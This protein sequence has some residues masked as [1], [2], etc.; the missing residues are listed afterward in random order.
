MQKEMKRVVTNLLTVKSIVTLMLT[1]V[2]SLLAVYGRISGEQFL[3]IFSVVIAFYFGTQYQ[4]GEQKGEDA[5]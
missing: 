1:A 2:F 4:K 3:N 5:S